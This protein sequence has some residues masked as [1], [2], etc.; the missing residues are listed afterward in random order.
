VTFAAEKTAAAASHEFQAL[1]LVTPTEEHYFKSPCSV[2]E[3]RNIIA[4]RGV[5]H[6]VQLF[7]RT[8]DKLVLAHA[9]TF[10]GNWMM[11]PKFPVKLSWALNVALALDALHDMGLMHRDLTLSNVVYFGK[12]A[13]LIDLECGPSSIHILPPEMLSEPDA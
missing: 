3:I 9:G 11:P 4:Y 10:L 6:I 12:H 8:S 7:R 1:E 2:A 13:T 5:L